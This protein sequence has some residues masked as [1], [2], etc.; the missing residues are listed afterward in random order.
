[1]MYPTFA[2]NSW[3]PTV[4]NDL[5]DA[6]YMPKANATA[7]AINGKVGSE[8]KIVSPVLKGGMKKLTFSYGA[9]YSDKLL[10]F[11]VDV[12]QNGNV[13]QSWTESQDNA[14]RYQVYSFA[15]DCNISGDFTIEITNLC[16]SNS[17]SNKDRVAIWNLVWEK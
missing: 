15:K 8:G 13:V 5:F 4:F 2:R 17:T 3:L 11:R 14:V 6:D 7:P 1:M 16:P 9:P 10:S 12:K